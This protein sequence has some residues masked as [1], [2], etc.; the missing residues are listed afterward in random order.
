V[1]SE[2]AL[3]TISGY[4]PLPNFQKSIIDAIDRYLTLNPQNLN[5]EP[6]TKS[7]NE[8]PNLFIEPA[9]ILGPAPHKEQ[10]L[11]RLVRSIQSIEI[12]E[13]GRWAKL[14]RLRSLLLNVS[15]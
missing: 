13:I 8:A 2:L 7:L 11:V 5:P 4:K 1:L 15:A 10:E 9:P 6:S 12:S 3:P 14:V